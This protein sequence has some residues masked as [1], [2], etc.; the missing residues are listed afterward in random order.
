MHRVRHTRS[1]L[2]LSVSKYKASSVDLIRSKQCITSVFQTST[3]NIEY[4][5]NMFLQDQVKL[6]NKLVDHAPSP[7]FLT[8]SENANTFGTWYLCLKIEHGS[9]LLFKKTVYDRNHVALSKT[10]MK[11]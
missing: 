8:T 6:Y 3:L 9:S 11:Q 10:G 4:G 5:E 2:L 1:F 7:I